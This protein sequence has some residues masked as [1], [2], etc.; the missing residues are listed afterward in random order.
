MNFLNYLFVILFV[1]KIFSFGSIIFGNSFQNWLNAI[2]Q[3]TERDYGY[4]NCEGIIPESSVVKHGERQKYYDNQ[5]VNDDDDE[6]SDNQK[7]E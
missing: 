3:H 2:D 4:L 1:L 6:G 5:A 7:E